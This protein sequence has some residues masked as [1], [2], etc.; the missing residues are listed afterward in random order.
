MTRAVLAILHLFALAIGMSSID[1][2]SRALRRFDRSPLALRDALIADSWWGAAG[3]LWLV[4]GLWRWLGGMEKAPAYYLGNPFFHA[5][6]GLLVV[7]L[8]LEAWP[9]GT[10]MR[11]RIAQRRGALTDA[12]ALT[13]EARR[14]ARLSRVQSVIVLLMVVMAVLVARGY[15]A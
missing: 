10:L 2:R 3:A 8:V 14:L 1:A 15:G 6:L 11:W 5:K 9:I 4:T 7:L 12:A 13:P